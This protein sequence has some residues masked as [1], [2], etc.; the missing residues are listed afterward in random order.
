V[1]E[2][3]S[4]RLLDSRPGR[5][6]AVVIPALI[7]AGLIAGWI[8]ILVRSGGDLGFETGSRASVPAWFSLTVLGFFALVAVAFTVRCAVLVRQ[9]P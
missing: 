2:R 3:P 1:P 7:A 5:V 8:S 9:R 6:L 4:I